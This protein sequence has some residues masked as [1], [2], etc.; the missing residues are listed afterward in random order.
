MSPFT[1]P[2]IL[3]ILVLGFLANAGCGDDSSSNTGG[4]G[5]AGMLAPAGTG[6]AGVSVAGTGAAGVGSA[7]I[8][9][10]GTGAAGTGAAGT[11]AAGT[12]VA[13][14]GVAGT[15][16]AGAPAAG[17]GAGGCGSE[18][19]AA[20]YRDILASPT[21][22]CSSAPCHG[23]VGMLAAVGN[24]DL[25]TPAAAHAALVNKASD[26]TDC[27]GKSRVTPGNAAGSLLVTK[28]RDATVD[29]GILMPVGG[30]PI[31]DPELARIVAWINGGACNN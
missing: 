20:I 1:F 29:C 6:A 10:A 19:F 13:G 11:G 5:A 3:S 12:G 2:I 22:S 21:Y 4:V 30:D 15:G 31:T 8:G 23:R 24:L 14:T 28:L 18:S 27:A 16:V 26:S 17:S 25:S 9:V 7:G